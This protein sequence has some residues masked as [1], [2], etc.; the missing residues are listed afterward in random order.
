MLEID[1]YHISEKGGRVK[2]HAVVEG[3]IVVEAEI[4]FAMVKK[5][6]I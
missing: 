6:N 2:A 4:S 5:E 1:G 3:K